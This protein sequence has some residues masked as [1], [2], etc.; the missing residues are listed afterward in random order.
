MGFGNQ[1][2]I[3]LWKNYLVRKRQKL[4][5][6]IEIIWPLLLFL[7][8]MWVRTRGLRTYK[9]GCYYDEKALPSVG[10]LPFIQT[11][12]CTFSNP[13]HPNSE[14]PQL[15]PLN[16]TKINLIILETEHILK[17]DLNSSDSVSIQTVNDEFMTVIPSFILSY[18]RKRY[19]GVKGEDLSIGS[20]LPK[21]FATKLSNRGLQ[22]NFDLKKVL[23]HTYIS[24]SN[25]TNVF[26]KILTS[27]YSGL[28][29]IVCQEILI[30][31]D[32]NATSL[33]DISDSD[34]NDI[35]NEIFNVRSPEGYFTL[36]SEF[37]RANSNGNYYIHV[38]DWV[39]AYGIVD[40][41]VRQVLDTELARD[42]IKTV[43]DILRNDSSRFQSNPLAFMNRVVCGRSKIYMETS[44]S[45][46]GGLAKLDEMGRKFQVTFVTSPESTLD[47][48][49]TSKQ[50]WDLF[51]SFGENKFGQFVWRQMKPFVLGKILYTPNTPA[52]D[53]IMSKVKSHFRIVNQLIFLTDYWLK[54]ISPGLQKYLIERP[55]TLSFLKN[56]TGK[57]YI[58][59]NPFLKIMWNKLAAFL[60][61]LNSEIK[62]SGDE[63][64]N[65][66]HSYFTSNDLLKKWNATFKQTD[67]LV[68]RTNQVLK[69]F[70]QEKLQS[71]ANEDEAVVKALEL[72]AQDRLWAVVVFDNLNSTLKDNGTLPEHVIYKI[73]MDADKVDSTKRVHDRMSRPGARANPFI[74]LK[75]FTFGFIYLQDM[76]ENA[77]IN[78]QTG[79]DQLP[80]MWMQ[81]FPYPCYIYDQ[82]I[83][84][85]SRTFP[86]FM[87][88][89]WVYPAAMIIKT[90]VHEKERRLKEITKV[91]GLGNGV[92]W[93]GWFMNSFVVMMVTVI[94]LTL[95][96]KGGDIL[97]RS[98]M[99]VIW[100]FL[101]LYMCATINFSFFVSSFFS[102][103]NISAAAGGIIFFIT[104]LPY[105]FLILWEEE[106]VGW[107]KA[108]VSIFSNVAF[109]F[110]CSY[111]A[112]YEEI[113]IGLQW[114][115]IGKSPLYG[116][117][118]NMAKCMTILAFDSFLYGFLT[119]YIEAVFPG[120]FGVPKPWYMPFGLP[121]W[122]LR[123]RL[124]LF[125]R[126][127]E[128]QSEETTEM[129]SLNPNN[130]NHE[131]EPTDLPLGVRIQNLRKV[132]SDGKVA[133]ESLSLDFYED[134]ITSFLGH[135]GA[136]KT[137]TISILTGLFPPTSG[138]VYIYG[139]DIRTHMDEIRKSLGTCP[140][141]NVLFDHLTVEEHLL[142]YSQ[143]RGKKR[144]RKDL[145]V[146]LNQM[147]EDIGLPHK[148][149]ELSR[150]LSGGM[151][152]KLSVAIA[153]VDGSRTVILDEPTAGVDPF[154]RRAIWELLLKYK[155]GRTI[156][157]TTHH[158]DEADLLGD[159]IAIV[160]NGRLCCSGSS[161]FLKRRYANG[162]YLTVARVDESL[163]K[164][165]ESDITAFIK[166]H[167]DQ[168]WLSE[169]V[170]TELVYV[171]PTNENNIS[172]Y[173]HLFDALDN[174]S[175]KLGIASY[176]VSDTTLDEIFI[177][178]TKQNL[179]DTYANGNLKQKTCKIRKPKFLTNTRVA[180]NVTAY[181]NYVVEDVPPVSVQ[182]EIHR[183]VSGW[184]LI[185]KHI[186]AVIIKRFHHT[187]RD[188]K[189]LF[190][191][192]VLPSL[193]V[194]LALT[195]TLILP[196]MRM[197]PALNLHPW[198]YGPPN[199][200]FFSNENPNDVL[201][202]KYEQEFVGFPGIGTRCITNYTINLKSCQPESPTE[203]FNYP[204]NIISKLP[205]TSCRCDDGLQVCP[206]GAAGSPFPAK[207]VA[208]T[209]T[210][211]NTTGRQ[212][213]EWLMKTDRD[214]Y[215]ERYGGVTFGFNNPVSSFNA[216]AVRK[217]ID[218]LVKVLQFDKNDTD[219]VLFELDHGFRNLP[220]F[221]NIKVWF[222]NRGWASSVSYL[223][224]INNVV[225]RAHLSK[226][227]P[228]EAYGITAINHPLNFT[229]RQV[230]VEVI[231]RSGITVLHAICIMFAMSFVPASFV[232]YLIE[233][234][235]NKSKHLQFVTGLRPTVYWTSNFIWDNINY[236]MSAILCIL[237]F[238]M[239]NEEAYVSSTNFPGLVL[240]LVLYGW[241]TIPTMYP[242]VFIFN[243]PSTAFVA[244]ASTNLF[245]GVV[246]TISTFILELMDDQELQEIA[247][248]LKVIF[249]IFPH[250]C[251]GRGLIEMAT[252]HIMLQSLKGFGI[253]AERNPLAWDFLGRGLFC[254]FLQGLIMFSLTL[255]IEYKFFKHYFRK[256][257][258]DVLLDNIE[259]EDDVGRERDKVQSGRY[260]SA[261][262]KVLNLTKHYI[263]WRRGHCGKDQKERRLVA[264]DRLCFAVGRGECFGLLGVNGAGKTTT[265]KMLTQDIAITFGDAFVNGYSVQK[266]MDEARQHLGYCP[267]FDALDP[268]LTA[269]EHLTFYGSIRGI[270]NEDIQQI[271]RC[272]IS[273]MNLVE[274][275]TK[276]AGKYSGGNKRKLSTAIALVGNPSLIYLDEPT[277][278]MDPQ[279]RRFL[280][281]C[282]SELVKEGRSLI[283]TSHS[284]EECEALC[285]R[286]A[287][288]VN[289]RL[290]CIGS[291]Q[292]LKNKYGNGYSLTVKVSRDCVNLEAVKSFMNE[293]FPL[294]SVIEE[295]HNQLVFQLP[296]QSFVLS[297]LFNILE[298][299]K[300]TL[301]IEDYSVCQTSL[302]QVFI[303]FAKQQSHLQEET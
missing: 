117:T 248:L 26:E 78:I 88:L 187:R 45:I 139:L 155:K 109:G 79:F 262:L 167:V 226:D 166:S 144:N 10:T 120:Q 128:H 59:A 273:K 240:L 207:I 169:D 132:Y 295:H 225:L 265:F 63:L 46:E 174:N 251:L 93:M 288:M 291:I 270:V 216:T 271:V 33:C 85:I 212:L 76:I 189:A 25:L 51:K 154:S 253:H 12:Y 1:L 276:C 28:K 43:T 254:M 203:W 279:A 101:T 242:A 80:G 68:N 190:C 116:D 160:S 99:S 299:T 260:D 21:D 258:T 255:L 204:E 157:L 87:V 77:I 277:T 115:N 27:D 65:L 159:R 82:F 292:H 94:F 222:N 86:M 151:Q 218:P 197:E 243:V 110:G 170:G 206:A 301:K 7:I 235:V 252:S 249:L 196:P 261:I 22:F 241:A 62:L 266:Q 228:F 281:N 298:S 91:M 38:R 42:V 41:T 280:W 149:N 126:N 16:F 73:R 50:C 274:H 219:N 191:E 211:L 36:I 40:S 217:S 18:S 263:N 185:R 184:R 199:Y 237:I 176:G 239:F 269:E 75:Y 83:L 112:Q 268:L 195:F 23:D 96:L 114:S 121:S 70:D 194:C 52:A 72:V 172:S 275:A 136:G 285:T 9:P 210:L 245:I 186:V 180:S 55:E 64:S 193:F 37:M 133:I 272:Q 289:G 39:R 106:L 220:I 257:K 287:V 124:K 92:H 127:N 267:Q 233:D 56:I 102:R 113:G 250:Y 302:D 156:L 140:Q 294:S 5:L 17:K 238:V 236:L 6:A 227:K 177:K 95:I 164:I 282:V 141:H 108:I 35:I 171:L 290:S 213:S 232:L 67:T 125:L 297:N 183:K 60:S 163:E 84:A 20:L 175:N 200:V 89:S 152:R 230:E 286:L 293:K 153:F 130:E 135:N 129:Q 19:S 57:D 142:F 31:T 182:P 215:K 162:Y 15:V 256:R 58:E 30:H 66:T 178:I 111:F 134:Q 119:L 104:Y 148:R 264:V 47:E 146:E 145:E 198:L 81:Q 143:L 150:N 223:N 284:L 247:S 278:G 202:I 188:I 11:F 205:E 98:D 201:A 179:P 158:M 138:T 224:A 165:S 259:D 103:A 168:A 74:D 131:R 229:R 244:L 32:N 53:K 214:Y 29:Q 54:N 246:S 181:E 100:V 161:L 234:R 118:F 69:C 44:Q 49:S 34:F 2:K 147:I 90:V 221:N 105:P 3:L 209:D 4:R 296:S 123:T 71:V 137:T 283:L 8:L 303:N 208:T 173:S 61:A 48:N 122:C 300:T 14:K 97:I 192:I 13:C 24:L 231:K 107:E